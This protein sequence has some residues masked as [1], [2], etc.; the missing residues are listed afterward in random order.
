MAQ[1]TINR[2]MVRLA[3]R[4]LD[5]VRLKGGDPSVFGRV[6]EE[7]AALQAEALLSKAQ[8]LQ[9][10]ALLVQSMHGLHSGVNA[11]SG[12]FSVGADGVMLRDGA[13]ADEAVA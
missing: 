2:L 4:G 13:L 3:W 11:V 8:P 9:D 10:G 5:V 1:A 6:G 7:M 12:D